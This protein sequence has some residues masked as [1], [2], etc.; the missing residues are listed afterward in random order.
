MPAVFQL[1]ELRLA[2]FVELIVLYNSVSALCITKEV[3][4]A[5]AESDREVE[6]LQHTLS[7]EQRV[8]KKGEVEEHSLQYYILL[9]P[10]LDGE[11]H[12]ER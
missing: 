8:V 12:K 5:V 6:V 1:E 9:S 7:R 11:S 10:S 3:T 2:S 4:G